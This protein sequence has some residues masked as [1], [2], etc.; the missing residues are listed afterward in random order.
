MKPRQTVESYWSVWILNRADFAG[1]VWEPY[2]DGMTTRK[3]AADSMRVYAKRW[4]NER[5]AIVRTVNT[6]RPS[7]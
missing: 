3:A 1:P 5:Y 2:D 6:R 7:P 4:P